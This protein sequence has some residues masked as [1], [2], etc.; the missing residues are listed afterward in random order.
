MA[1]SDLELLQLVEKAQ[2]RQ[3]GEKGD[4][5][6]GIA[7]IEQFDENSVTIRLT[8]GNF[9][10][11]SLPKGND[12]PVG[13]AG[14]QGTPGERGSDG[15]PGRDG[16]AGRDGKDGVSGPAGVSLDTAIV[17]S[18]GHLLL[19]LTDGSIVDVGRVVGPAGPTGERGGTGLAGKPGKDG[20]SRSVWTTCSSSGRRSR[21][22]SLD[23]CKQRVV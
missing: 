23:R 10:K 1:M 21:R 4:P 17:N 12:G 3:K 7:S 16:A 15:R 2:E 19:G 14:I 22:R 20:C 11:V 13:P 9:K 5:G 18:D 8:D 6:V